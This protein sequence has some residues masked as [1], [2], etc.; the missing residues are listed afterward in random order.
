MQSIAYRRGRR[1]AHGRTGGPTPEQPA[2]RG[3]RVVE[4]EVAALDIAQG[5]CTAPSGEPA[6]PTDPT[7]QADVPG[8]GM[9]GNAAGVTA[10][11]MASAAQGTAAA[12]AI[13]LDLVVEDARTAVGQGRTAERSAR[14][15]VQDGC[16]RARGRTAGTTEEAP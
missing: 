3:V 6:C 9:G 16:P 14:R 8:V 15:R 4:E 5:W 2:A 11:V 1:V 13:D 10:Q 12:T 7:G